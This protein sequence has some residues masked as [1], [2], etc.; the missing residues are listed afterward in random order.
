[1]KELRIVE[2]QHQD[3]ERLIN[4]RRREGPNKKKGKERVD[5]R[6]KGRNEK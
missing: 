3:K 6:R 2:S 4:V 1:M 5:K